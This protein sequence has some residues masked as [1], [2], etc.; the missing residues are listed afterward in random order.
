MGSLWHS[1]KRQNKRKWLDVVSVPSNPKNLESPVITTMSLLQWK[2]QIH[3]RVI[4]MKSTIGLNP[5]LWPLT[6]IQ[7]F[8]GS[9]GVGTR[10]LFKSYSNRQTHGQWMIHFTD[11]ERNEE[12][13]QKMA[14]ILFGNE[15]R[16]RRRSARLWL[17]GIPCY[18]PKSDCYCLC[19]N[20]CSSSTWWDVSS[21]ILIS[22]GHF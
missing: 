8:K 22:S 5:I 9:L 13:C 21:V 12:E 4:G 3:I 2:F 17:D 11:S 16:E 18:S 19:N 15:W 7:A 14:N 1:S 6:I 20:Y 10:D